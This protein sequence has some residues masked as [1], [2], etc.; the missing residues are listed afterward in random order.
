MTR[1]EL[2]KIFNEVNATFDETPN[3]KETIDTMLKSLAEDKHP[4]EFIVLNGAFEL[5]K[6]FMFE[7]MRKVLCDDLSQTPDTRPQSRD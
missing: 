1:A 2:A 4:H 3:C 6:Q 7:V 5:S